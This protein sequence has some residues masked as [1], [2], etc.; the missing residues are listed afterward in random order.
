MHFKTI[1]LVLLVAQPARSLRAQT[2]QPSAPG[3]ADNS[4]LIEEAYNQESGVVQH[5]SAFQR[6]LRNQ[7]W[8]YTF[9]QEWPVGGQRHQLSFTVPV[10]RVAPAGGGFTG[11]GDIGL[12]YRYQLLG[13][14]RRVAAAPRLSI[15]VPTGNEKHAL[16]SGGWGVQVNLPVS[17]ALSSR[18]VTHWNAGATVTPAATN[19]LGEE[20]GVHAYAFGGSIIWQARRTFH[21]LWETLWTRTEVITGPGKTRGEV[22]VTVNPGIRWAHNF[23][24]GLQIVPGIAMPIGLGPSWGERGLFFYLSIEHGFRRQAVRVEN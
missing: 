2:Q 14:A 19:E 12:N 8:S 18:L 4:F 16:G 6:S 5:I 21:V 10:Q 1:I 23:P 9:T 24:S 15:L 3:I 7:E 17:I 20:A 11:L 13:A 22:S